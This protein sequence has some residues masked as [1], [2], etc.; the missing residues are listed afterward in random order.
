VVVSEEQEGLE[1]RIAAGLA[2]VEEGW[3][4]RGGDFVSRRRPLPDVPERTAG[5]GADER[6]ELGKGLPLLLVDG[7]QDL[8]VVEEREP[9]VGHDPEPHG[10][11]GER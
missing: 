2:P 4:A 11:P 10:G 7:G 8:R 9:L 6:P 5:T 3:L 1:G